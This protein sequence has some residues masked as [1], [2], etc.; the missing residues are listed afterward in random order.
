MPSAAIFGAG[1]AFGLSIARR[2]AARGHDV[3]LIARDPAKLEG[4]ATQLAPTGVEVATFAADLADRPQ[5]RDA[6]AAVR[7][8]F[9]LPDAV[10]YAPG[11]VTRLPVP[12]LELTP[13]VLESWLPLHLLSPLALGAA[14]LGPMMARG[15]GAFLVVQGTAARQPDPMLASVGAAQAALRNWL[16]AAAA[17]AGPR[18]VRVRALLVGA[19]IER[20]AAAALFDGG[21][22]AD[23]EPG[24]LPRVDPDD[25]ADRAWSELLE[26]ETAE[27]ALP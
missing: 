24:S 26:S 18:G 16:H 7:R 11:D 21:R 10:V 1:P 19:L 6:L 27:L 20:S 4:L 13:E 23:V 17:Q 22:F 14:L 25:L 9:G 5:V 15:S 8:R 3:A 2:F 12:A